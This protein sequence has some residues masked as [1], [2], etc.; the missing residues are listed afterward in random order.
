VETAATTAVTTTGKKG[1]GKEPVRGG[2]RGHDGHER[3]P[4]EISCFHPSTNMAVKRSFEMMQEARARI[5]G[6][7]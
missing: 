7:E 1:K 4:S 2:D 5:D 3:S 6:W